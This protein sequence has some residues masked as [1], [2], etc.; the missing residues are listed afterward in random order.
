M[1]NHAP[2]SRLE[3]DRSHWELPEDDFLDV[4]VLIHSQ[5]H[6]PSYYMK[7]IDIHDV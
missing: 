4:L 1:M 6:Q 5:E 2:D 3:T 7:L